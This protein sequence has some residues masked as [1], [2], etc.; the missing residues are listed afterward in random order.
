MKG[1]IIPFLVSV[2][3]VFNPMTAFAAH[4]GGGHASNFSHSGIS[5]SK[6]SHSGSF[7]NSNNQ[8]YHSGYK[9]ASSN[10]TQARTFNPSVPKK[11]SGLLSHAA[12]FG[13]GA[14]LGSMF[15]PF[16]GAG[17]GISGLIMDIIIIAVIV[18]IVRKLFSRRAY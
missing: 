8:T 3:I 13:A 14:L 4:F 18:F 11:S 12:A 1:K 6:S 7:S 10:V 2:L 15:H 9:N 16:G 17:H 5:L